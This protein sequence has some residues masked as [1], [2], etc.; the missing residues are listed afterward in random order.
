MMCFLRI[1]PERRSTSDWARLVAHTGLMRIYGVGIT[2][3]SED[4]GKMK[5]R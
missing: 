2:K 3:K 5:R 4:E 1:C